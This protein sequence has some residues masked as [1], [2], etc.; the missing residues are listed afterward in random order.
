MNF[1]MCWSA[2]R[3]LHLWGDAMTYVLMFVRENGCP[4]FFQGTIAEINKE[5][6][7]AWTNHEI[8]QDSWDYNNAWMLLGVE[9]GRLTLINRCA[10]EN[11]P[12]VSVDL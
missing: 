1:W 5:L 12:Q 3:N 9:D 4:D 2:L 11:I 7:D 6:K 10:I 8:D